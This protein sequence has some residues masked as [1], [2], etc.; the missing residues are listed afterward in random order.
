MPIKNHRAT[1]D[2]GTQF[3]GKAFNVIALSIAFLETC[4][5]RKTGS[6][7]SAAQVTNK[8]LSGML[9]SCQ[10]PNIKEVLARNIDSLKATVN[11]VDVQQKASARTTSHS[12]ASKESDDIGRTLD[13]FVDLLKEV[14]DSVVTNTTF[15]EAPYVGAQPNEFKTQV[16][17]KHDGNTWVYNIISVGNNASDLGG[18]LSYSYN[19]IKNA[20]LAGDAW[21]INQIFQLLVTR[22]ATNAIRDY[23]VEEA[24]KHPATVAKAK[25]IASIVG[26]NYKHY[27][28]L[29][30]NFDAYIEVLLLQT[31]GKIAKE[32]LAYEVCKK[33]L[34][35]SDFQLKEVA[36]LFQEKPLFH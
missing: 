6:D 21:R 3:N 33:T 26:G 7:M 30:D 27:L 18:K 2:E 4:N 10:F 15:D 11:A 8:V 19:G 24:D 22:M 12:L 17:I 9:A 36:K 23:L 32:N 29:V 1:N 14:A 5:V 16:E 34:V 20:E 31:D 25:S 35:S 13:F 28:V